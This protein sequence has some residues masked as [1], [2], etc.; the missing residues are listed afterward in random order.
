MADIMGNEKTPMNWKIFWTFFSVIYGALV[1]PLSCDIWLGSLGTNIDIPGRI[2]LTVLILCV[3]CPLFSSGPLFA[4]L[5]A[6]KMMGKRYLPEL[7][8][9][10]EVLPTSRLVSSGLG[11]NRK[12]QKLCQA[13]QVTA[14]SAMTVFPFLLLIVVLGRWNE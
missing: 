7:L 5:N 12:A 8:F 3:I 13:L 2:T 1:V 11:T 9:P 14:I 6:K 4:L 10:P